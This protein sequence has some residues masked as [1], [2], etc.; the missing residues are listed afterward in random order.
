MY[1]RSF[2]VAVETRA[3]GRYWW[4]VF[5]SCSHFWGTSRVVSKMIFIVYRDDARLM[6]SQPQWGCTSDGPKYTLHSLFLSQQK[7]NLSPLV[8]VNVNT[9]TIFP[10][11]SKALNVNTNLHQ[12][13]II[14][15]VSRVSEA[16][17]SSADYAEQTT[18]MKSE[19]QLN[20][21]HWT[22]VSCNKLVCFTFIFIIYQLDFEFIKC[23]TLVKKPKWHVE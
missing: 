8:T 17:S 14:K 18:L 19:E 22:L 6:T 2:L 5:V 21:M 15:A 3:A 13:D 12:Q 4:A 10:G 1:C 16:G 7:R 20:G 9:C 23:H 11:H